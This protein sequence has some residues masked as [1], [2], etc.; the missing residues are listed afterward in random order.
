M[1]TKKKKILTEKRLSK[2][3]AILPVLSKGRTFKGIP[4]SPGIAIGTAHIFE[5]SIDQFPRYWISDREIPSEIRRF[6]QALN[7]SHHQLFQIQRKICKFERADH[8]RILETH[9]MLTK[10]EML[11]GATMDLIQQEHI[12][13]EW[14]LDKAL[15]KLKT[16]FSNIK[17]DLFRE[18]GFDIEHVSQRILKNLV[19][20]LDDSPKTYKNQSIIVSHDLSP[21]DTVALPKEIIEG[22]LTEIGGKTSHVAIIARALEIP[23]IAGVTNITSMIKE[24]DPLI[25]DGYEGKII[26]HPTKKEQEYY[27]EL[28]QDF[29]QKEHQLLKEAKAPTITRD[30]YSIRL[31]ANMELTEEIPTIKSHGA[32]GIGLYR[33]EMLFLKSEQL[34]TEEEQFQIYKKTVQSLSPYATTIRTIDIG[35]DKLLS[36]TDSL[37]SLNPALGLRAIRFCLREKGLFKTQLRAILRASQY[38][39]L[40]ILLPMI[41]IIEELRQA[42]KIIDDVKED[43]IDKKIPF[44]KKIPIGVMIEVPSAALMA[45]ALAAEVDFMSIGTND[46]I[47]YTLAV[48]RTNEHVAYLY[49]PL[50]PS[51]LSLLKRIVYAAK[52]MEI[53]VSI[54]GEMANEPLYFLILLG[55]G[56]TEL[57]MNPV[58]IP[59]AKQIIRQLSFH[60]ATET[61]DRALLCKT[62]AEV[63]TLLRKEAAKI[64]NFP[65]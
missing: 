26:L 63:E 37:D 65:I 44:D 7:I 36:S 8:S 58:S 19:G 10:D 2:S 64:P 40:K 62:T 59:R 23:A 35:G 61:L 11:T 25:I 51:I 53:D 57:S 45:D 4:V 52:K 29:V 21:S 38:G 20:K 46:L 43:L 17:N 6:K 48:D 31:T 32:E 50:N 16:N 18:R 27:K 60:K 34:P 13:A 5:Q 30:G 55:L 42:K 56:L 14:A 9:Q 12:N 22:L 49:Q 24:G 33:T 41:T 39:K 15:S 54:C 1:K 28:R 47:Q 3:T